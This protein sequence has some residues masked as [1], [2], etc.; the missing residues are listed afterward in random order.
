MA[1]GQVID[2]FRREYVRLAPLFTEKMKR[3]WAGG[4]AIEVGQGGISAAAEITD[5]ARNTV[6]AGM[7]DVQDPEVLHSE[8]VRRPGA[9][10]KSAVERDPTLVAD[11]LTLVAPATRG[12]PERA[13]RWSS[14][15]LRKLTVELQAQGHT[16]SERTVSKVLKQEG[17]SLQSPRKVREGKGDHPDRDQQF[18]FIA[19]QVASFQ[20]AGQPVISIDTK[21]KNSLATS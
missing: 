2:A 1:I 16:V 4:V 11:L 3:L 10:R 17:Y 9:G 20:E 18:K 14:K 13:L 6:R 15:S 5:L 21:K 12:D 8:R 7:R 19:S